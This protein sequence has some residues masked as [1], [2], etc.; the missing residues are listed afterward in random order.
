MVCTQ[1]IGFD[2]IAASAGSRGNRA[3]RALRPLIA[4]SVLHAIRTLGQVC[5]SVRGVVAP[6]GRK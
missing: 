5:V 4:M 6:G 2:Q 3:P 1:V